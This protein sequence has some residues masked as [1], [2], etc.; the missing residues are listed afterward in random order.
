MVF[1]TS[2]IISL[3]RLKVETTLE[4]EVLWRLIE[5]IRL[6]LFASTGFLLGHPRS[7]LWGMNSYSAITKEHT[8][9]MELQSFSSSIAHHTALPEEVRQHHVLRGN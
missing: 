7:S 5:P 1:A 3:S 2:T 4:V 9:E 6:C 8:T